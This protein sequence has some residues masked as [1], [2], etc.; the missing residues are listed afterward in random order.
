MPKDRTPAEVKEIR[1]Q[2][3]RRRLWTG[4]GFFA[5][6]WAL[7]ITGLATGQYWMLWVGWI[8]I[9][10]ELVAMY[11]LHET[12]LRKIAGRPAPDYRKIYKL[13]K[14]IPPPGQEKEE[15]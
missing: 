5:L 3:E 4:L 10:G 14:K 12:A 2:R 7:F 11:G 15:T 8:A 1:K 13:Q 6:W 9:S